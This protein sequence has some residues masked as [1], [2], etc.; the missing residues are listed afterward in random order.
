[1]GR[2]DE[3]PR[4]ERDDGNEVETGRAKK[5]RVLHTRVPAVLEQE[6]KRLAGALKVPVSNLV[7]AILE[8]AIDAVDAVGRKA[9]G[10]LHGIA[11]H[12]ARRRDSLRTAALRAATTGARKAARE[13]P[14]AE[15]ETAP[16]K[17]RSE[18]AAAAPRCPDEPGDALDGVIGF[19]SLVLATDA[20]C[21][22]CGVELMRGS[23]AAR[24]VREEPGPRVLLGPRCRLLPG[25]HNEE[26]TR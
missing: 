17:G 3:H 5:E 12:L 8:D 4:A 22:V 18:A 7:R 6:L 11:E 20:T 9:E 1:V 13:G 10:E 24:G 16:E 19:E 25:S 21:T 14:D 2:N 15:Y 23:R 26:E